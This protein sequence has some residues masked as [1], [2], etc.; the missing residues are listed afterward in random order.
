LDLLFH[1]KFFN[2]CKTGYFKVPPRFV[3]RP[4]NIN[5][6]LK[7]DAEL[8]CS[9][10]GVPTPT[11]QWFKN[12]EPIYPSEYFQFSPN[13]GNLKILGIIAQDEGYYQCLASNELNTVQSVAKLNVQLSDDEQHESTTFMPL[14]ASE[15]TSETAEAVK[16]KQN[17]KIALTESTSTT[18]TSKR[19]FYN[20]FS[21]LAPLQNVAMALSGSPPIAPIVHLSAPTDLK[22]IRTSPR[23]LHVQWQPPSIV[24]NS[25]QPDLS[26]NHLLYYISWRQVNKHFLMTACK[27]GSR[28][29][30][31]LKR[32]HPHLFVII[33]YF[34]VISRLVELYKQK[35]SF[36]KIFGLRNVKKN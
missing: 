29:K 27:F 5:V 26:S 13:H 12:G 11:V 1:Y 32:I 15:E 8:E 36:L 34:Y 33:I 14:S 21:S 31:R 16:A 24:R 7:S 10:Y 19:A 2:F 28:L 3:K 25:P 30:S 9:A 22:V 4:S 18:T 35:L 6:T 17:N 20:S 23:S